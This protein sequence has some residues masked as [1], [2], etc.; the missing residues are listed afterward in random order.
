MYNKDEKSTDEFFQERGLTRGDV[1]TIRYPVPWLE[2]E[3]IS[4]HKF[5]VDSSSSEDK[6]MVQYLN[7]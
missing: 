2:L 6:D 7:N 4:Y 1:G 5:L 3:Y